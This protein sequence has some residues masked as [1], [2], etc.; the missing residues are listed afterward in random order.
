MY[1]F[2]KSALNYH[3]ILGNCALCGNDMGSIHVTILLFSYYKISDYTWAR[4]SDT[5]F[6]WSG[7]HFGRTTMYKKSSHIFVISA[8]NS[9]SYKIWIF[10]KS[11]NSHNF[12][13]IFSTYFY[14][15]F[16][17][18]LGEKWKQVHPDETNIS[19]HTRRY[20]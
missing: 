8:R 20:A 7:K 13:G 2:E 12:F 10:W 3:F 16:S 11:P 19:I 6:K 15:L 14:C 4:T 18:Y 1:L 9:S 17:N 5:Y